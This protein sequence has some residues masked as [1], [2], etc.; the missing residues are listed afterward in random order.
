[1]SNK[2]MI[3]DDN[4]LVRESVGFICE[5]HGLDLVRAEGG[6]E[7]LSLLEQGFRGVILMDI[8][9]PGLDGWQTIRE[10][11]AR[12]LYPG[13]LIVMLTGVDQ[14]T[15]AMEGLQEYVTDYLRKPFTPDFLC[16]RLRF[17]LSLLEQ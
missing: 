9:M 7:C 11:I 10:L 2:V 13:N 3:V 8:M 15:L 4:H 14:P 17:Y 12:G 1:M 5:E 6:A 16:E